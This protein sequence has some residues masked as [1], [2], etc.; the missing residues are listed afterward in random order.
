MENRRALRGYACRVFNLSLGDVNLPYRGGKVSPWASIL[1]TLA[2]ELD[3]LIVVS[4]GN[5]TYQP[6][7]DEFPDAHVNRYPRYLLDDDAK[8]IEPATGAIVLTVGSLSRLDA[9]PRGAGQDDV[10]LRPVAHA[11]GPSPFTRSGP[12][13]GGSVKPE[14]C[15]FG[16]NHAYDGRLNRIRELDELSA[17]SMNR[18]YLRRLFA[19]GIGSSYAAPRVAHIA[20]KLFQFFEG[21]SANLIRALMVSSAA[22]PAQS[23]TALQ[24]LGKNAV[25]QVCGY[26][27]ANFDRARFSDE[28]RVALYSQSQIGHN[29]FHV[30]QIP[31]PESFLE[32]RESRTIEITLAYDPPVRHSRFDYLGVT[33]SFR[34]FRGK[35]LD[36]IMEACRRQVEND[37]EV[38]GLGSTKWDCAMIPKP[39]VREGGTLQKAA[40]RMARIPRRE[41]GDVYH[42]VVRCEKK[43]ARDEHAP[44]RYAVVA[45]LQQET[46]VNIYQQISQRV[47]AAARARV[48]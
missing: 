9:L 2:R 18:D 21:A 7:P 26:G 32:S 37:D 4:S 40:F 45:V 34:L 33:M 1:D 23:A 48:R 43:W 11:L 17:V 42:L 20:A 41:Y 29:N 30:Y 12:G 47:R 6:R 5:F 3:V 35:S 38:E 44:Q 46:D 10:A 39:G 13:L 19:T 25:L 8:I 24:E 27:R 31:I 28:N 15:D 16:G 14:L 36:E 22:V